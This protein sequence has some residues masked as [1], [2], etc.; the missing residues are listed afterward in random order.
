M[1]RLQSHGLYE[2][3]SEPQHWQTDRMCSMNRADLWHGSRTLDMEIFCGLDV[4]V[5]FHRRRNRIQQRIEEICAISN[6]W[7]GPL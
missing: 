6:F 4:Q 5:Y 3:Y 2:I 7:M 1:E